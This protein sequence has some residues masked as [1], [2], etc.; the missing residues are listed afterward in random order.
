M[1]VYKPGYIDLKLIGFT[2]GAAYVLKL[3]IEK[4][5]DMSHSVG[6]YEGY[7]YGK[8]YG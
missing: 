2:V 5:T 8:L 1:P 6:S 4:G 7:K 3:G